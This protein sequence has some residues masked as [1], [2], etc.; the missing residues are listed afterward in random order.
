MARPPGALVVLEPWWSGEGPE[1]GDV[2]ESRTGRRWQLLEID[3]AL[4][5]RRFRCR[6]MAPEEPHPA[7]AV[8]F[9]WSWAPKPRPR[10]RRRR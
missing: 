5:R 1:P 9:A 2:L 4:G 3:T 8:R 10:P 7:G 6:V